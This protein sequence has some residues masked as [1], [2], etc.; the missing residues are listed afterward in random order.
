M[1]I[2]GKDVKSFFQQ[3]IGGHR[4]QRVPPTEKGSRVHTSTVTVALIE[5]LH[6]SEIEINLNDIEKRYTRGSGNGGQNKNKVH[7]CV[8]L[9]HKPTGISVRIDGRD[10][11]KNEKE[12]WRVLRERL[13][14]KSNQKFAKDLKQIR[15]D[16]IG[17]GFRGEK[18]RTYRVQD[19]IVIDHLTNKKIALTEIYKG[20]IER[21]HK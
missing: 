20:K 14:N 21:L 6:N 9:I 8:V 13:Q 15:Q 1:E 11:G 18:R 16:Q 2:S 7:S 4:W 3:E 10:Q 12:A 17:L 5:N 19:G